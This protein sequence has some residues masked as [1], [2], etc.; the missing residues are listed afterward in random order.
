MS[1]IYNRCPEYIICIQIL[2]YCRY[3]LVCNYLLVYNYFLIYDNEDS[4]NKS[5]I[6]SYQIF[7]QNNMSESDWKLY[8]QE[9]D[10]IFKGPIIYSRGRLYILNGALSL[11]NSQIEIKI[12]IQKIKVKTSGLVQR[13]ASNYLFMK[14]TSFRFYRIRINRRT[15]HVK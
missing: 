7:I 2:T 3:L 15:N 5:S 13:Q 12:I 8:I 11:V 9:A 14:L 10:Y 6:I 1:W 4:S